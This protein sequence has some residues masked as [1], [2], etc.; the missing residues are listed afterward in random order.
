MR[1]V[2][3][4]HGLPLYLYT[5]TVQVKAAIGAVIKGKHLN[6]AKVTVPAL[7]LDFL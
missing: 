2:M 5:I 4:T 6:L 7:G 1:A 3:E